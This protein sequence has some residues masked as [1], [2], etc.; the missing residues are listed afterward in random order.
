VEGTDR[1]KRGRGCKKRTAKKR[2]EDGQSITCVGQRVTTRPTPNGRKALK[3]PERDDVVVRG[4]KD[5]IKRSSV[6]TEPSTRTRESVWVGRRKVIK[7]TGATK[8]YPLYLEA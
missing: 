2:S 8:K 3:P 6:P 1:Y 7:K 4:E 5:G